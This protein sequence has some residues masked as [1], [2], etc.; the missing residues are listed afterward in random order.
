M[1][2][3]IVLAAFIFLFPVSRAHAFIFTDLVAQVQRFQMMGQAA[4]YI[5][6]LSTYR[7]EFQQ[8]KDTFDDYYES[9]LHVYSRVSPGDWS[10]FVPTIWNHLDD[11]YIL[12]WQTFDEAAWQTQ[13]VGLR[14]NPLYSVNADYRAY[15]ENLI[16]ISAEL[17]S[18]LKREEASLIELQ[19]QDRKHSDDLERF[20]SLNEA[21][22]VDNYEDNG[23]IALTQQ[24]ALT[25]AILIEMAS[26]QAETKL[27]E[28]RLL[29]TQMEQR[30]LIMRMKKLEVESQNGDIGNWN[31]IESITSED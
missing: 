30:N 28:Q 4:Q 5:W 17:V 21:L 25:N 9:F 29:T 26:I 15:A 18:R 3:T 20:K 10:D 27:I 1:K 19:D 22:S 14:L 31:Y 6:Q 12:F 11:H 16:G 8:Y 7:Q 23:A 24:L 2:K 13:V